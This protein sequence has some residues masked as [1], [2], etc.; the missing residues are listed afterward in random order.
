MEYDSI[1][2]IFINGK[3]NTGKGLLHSVLSIHLHDFLHTFLKENIPCIPE[4]QFVYI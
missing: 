1:D 2:Y 4:Q 3:I